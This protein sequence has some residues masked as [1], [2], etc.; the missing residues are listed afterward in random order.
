MLLLIEMKKL[1]Q[2]SIL[3]IVVGAMILF[4]TCSGGNQIKKQGFREKQ[5]AASFDKSFE[6]AF[7]Q[8]AFI[9]SDSLSIKFSN[10]AEDSRCPEGYDCV[11]QGQAKIAVKILSGNNDLGEINLTSLA[12]HDSLA[13]ENFNR[14]SIKLLKVGPPKRDSQLEL[15]D[16]NVM[17]LISRR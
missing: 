10:V 14:Y 12:G 1:V 8:T 9:E 15:S 6:L 3:I 2:V 11:W 13:H 7:D 16:Y 4:Y 5:I 17:L